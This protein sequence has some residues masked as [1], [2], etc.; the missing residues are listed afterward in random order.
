MKIVY[1]LSA[2]NSVLIFYLV[3]A[4][5]PNGEA[6]NL[7]IQ[8]IAAVLTLLAVLVAIFQDWIRYTLIPPKLKIELHNTKGELIIYGEEKKTIFYHLKVVN[9]RKWSP[10]KNCQVLLKEIKTKLHDSKFSSNPLTVQRNFHW[11]PA[12]LKTP[13]ISFYD[14]AVFDFVKIEFHKSTIE[15]CLNRY[16][17]NFEGYI[18]KDEVKRYVIQIKG[19]NIPMN[20]QTFQ[21]SWDGVWPEASQTHLIIEE[22]TE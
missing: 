11:T 21:V 4:T 3:A 2:V 20:K 18:E 10:A 17:F 7:T 9:Y 12:D 14:E 1:V 13:A 22:I 8:A 16:Y 6:I 15:P 19:D 5:T